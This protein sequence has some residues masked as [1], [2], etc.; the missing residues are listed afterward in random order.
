MHDKRIMEM[1]LSLDV[2]FDEFIACNH[3]QLFLKAT[4]LSDITTGDG[5]FLTDNAWTGIATPHEHRDKAWPKYHK[6]T[7][8]N[9]RIWQNWVKKAFLSHGKD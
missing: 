4:L 6:T 1:L 2:P 9:W 5:I 3:C 8:T 7:P